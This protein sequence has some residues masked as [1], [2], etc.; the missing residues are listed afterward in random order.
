M[1]ILIPILYLYCGN[2]AVNCLY[3]SLSC[4]YIEHANI[5]VY[6]YLHVYVIVLV[7]ELY[8]EL[9]SCSGLQ[10]SNNVIQ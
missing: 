6:V 10:E 3:T 8:L 7:H 1:V 4:T 9:L 2:A 5:Y